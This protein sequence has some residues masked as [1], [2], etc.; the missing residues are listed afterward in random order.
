VSNERDFPNSGILFRNDNKQSDRHPE[1]RGEVTITDPEWGDRQYWLSAWV[2][3]GN[4]RKYLR[5]RL[6]PKEPPPEPEFGTGT[7]DH[8][9]GFDL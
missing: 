8:E 3:T 2:N 1:Y 5:L 4:Q 6:R 7:P 9:D